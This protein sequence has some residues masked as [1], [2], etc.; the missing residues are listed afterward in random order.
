MQTSFRVK[1][2]HFEMFWFQWQGTA[3]NLNGLHFWFVLQS[4]CHYEVTMWLLSADKSASYMQKTGILTNK[5]EML[6]DE[7]L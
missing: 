6:Q 4:L 7:D 5:L 3:F 1:R 2:A